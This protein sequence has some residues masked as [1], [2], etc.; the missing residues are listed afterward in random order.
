VAPRRPA[1]LRDQLRARARRG[2]EPI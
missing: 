2:L 1:P